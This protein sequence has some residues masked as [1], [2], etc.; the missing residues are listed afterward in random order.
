MACARE[1]HGDPVVDWR[2]CG[3]AQARRPAAAAGG[4]T[5][6]A[7]PPDRGHRESPAHRSGHLSGESNATRGWNA[8]AGAG[9]LCANFERIHII[10]VISGTPMQGP[11]RSAART[12]RPAA[13]TTA[14]DIGRGVVSTCD[15]N[16]APAARGA[17]HSCPP[18]QRRLA[19]VCGIACM[20]C[21]SLCVED[22][23][24]DPAF[25]ILPHGKYLFARRAGRSACF[26][27]GRRGARR[28]ALPPRGRTRTDAPTSWRWNGESSGR[29]QARENS[30]RR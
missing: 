22:I 19:V 14:A 16:K 12:P 3:A 21:C 1:W 13:R 29:R 20:D 10:P 26:Q 30:E 8:G 27:P 9:G 15:K 28:R 5:V 2:S 4:A 24:E 6:H 7:A 11:G 17:P 25:V 18:S 23:L